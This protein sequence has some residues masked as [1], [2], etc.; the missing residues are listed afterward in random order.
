MKHLDGKA[1][2]SGYRKL[3]FAGMEGRWIWSTWSTAS[4]A[5]PLETATRCQGWSTN[6]IISAAGV[7]TTDLN[8]GLGASDRI[9]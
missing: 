7:A 8:Q 5:A 1:A 2:G 3:D 4:R 9:P 6:P